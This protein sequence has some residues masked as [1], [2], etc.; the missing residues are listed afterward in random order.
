MTFQS[1]HLRE[2]RQ[3]ESTHIIH[4]AV[5]IHAPTRGATQKRAIAAQKQEFQSTHLREVRHRV[6]CASTPQS[7]SIHEPT[8]GA[9]I[10]FTYAPYV[11]HVSIHAPTRGATSSVSS[12]S[13][14]CTCFNPRT[15]ERCD[16]SSGDIVACK[17]V[18]QSTH[19]REVRQGVEFLQAA[20]G[21]SIHA[22]TRGAT[23][24]QGLFH[25]VKIVSI[26]APT[27]GATKRG[28]QQGHRRRVSIHAP[29]R[30]ATSSPLGSCPILV[31]FNPRTYERCDSHL[32]A[33]IAVI[34]TFQSTHLRE[35]RPKG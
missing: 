21:V 23:S 24:W 13:P 30:G 20:Y 10:L 5:S 27:R 2:V 28:H 31:G 11:I 29:T 19:L 4:Q 35:V 32:L 8:R 3:D 18:F 25:L 12:S 6:L 7:V 9:T 33:R 1:T 17:R 22:P 15:Y 26:H 14:T 34:H 16:Y